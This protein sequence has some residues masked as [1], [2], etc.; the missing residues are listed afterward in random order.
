M[1]KCTSTQSPFRNG[2]VVWDEI[3]NFSLTVSK[4]W[5]TD[6]RL[7]IS[8]CVNYIQKTN[9]ISSVFIEY[10]YDFG[11]IGK[12]YPTASTTFLQLGNLFHRLGLE[13]SLSEDKP[14]STHMPLLGF[15]FFCWAF[16]FHA[17]Y[18]LFITNQS[19][20]INAFKILSFTVV[21]CANYD[22]MQLILTD[23]QVSTCHITGSQNVIV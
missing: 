4:Y 22:F 23:F 16:F 3:K 20:H 5:Q 6:V 18:L 2:R 19:L 14:P 10:V 7:N 12:E 8:L 21:S 1:I 13:F 15:V 17:T 11:G 9:L